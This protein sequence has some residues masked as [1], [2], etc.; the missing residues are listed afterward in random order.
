MKKGVKKIWALLAMLLI[1]WTSFL[2][3]LANAVF[4]TS[5]T[6]TF[7]MPDHNVN[8]KAISEANTYTIAFNANWWTGSMNSMSMTYD[9]TWTLTAN[10]F[11]KTW[12]TFQWWS[13]STDWDV[14]YADKATNVSNLTSTDWATV[15]L[16]AIWKANTYKVSFDK[17]EGVD[18]QNLVVWSMPVQDFI[19]D[20]SQQLTWNKFIRTWYTFQWWSTTANWAVVYADKANVSNLTTTSWGTVILYAKW[21]A[22][23]DTKYTVNH[24]LMGTGWEYSTPTDQ[25]EYE[26][27]T[28]E[29]VTALTGDYLWFTL[30]WSA[31]TWHVKWDWTTVFDYYYSRNKYDV[32]LHAWRG[33]AEVAWEGEYYYDDAISVSA[34]LKDWY[35][36][37]TLVWTWDKTTANFNM[38]AD[39]VDMTASATPF[40]YTITYDVWS[41][42][43]TWQKTTYNVEENFTLVD[44]TRTWY[45]FVWWSG[46]NLTSPTSWLVI[47]GV[48]GD[49]SYEAV[50]SPRSDITFVV[51]HY[52]KVLWED[53]YVEES[54]VTYNTWTADETLT[55]ADFQKTID[56][57]SYAWWSL[58]LS[59]SWLSSAISTTTVLPDGSRHIY[60]YYTRNVHSVTLTKDDHIASVNLSGT[61]GNTVTESFECWATVTI[62]ADPDTWYHFLRWDDLWP[63][64]LNPVNP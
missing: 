5:A 14:A 57:M 39:D 51:H 52:Q 58:V 45:D 17:N 60:L 21:N 41:W 29:V 10:S 43:I 23:T 12:Y 59:A 32:T 35:D 48:Y 33:I 47:S 2:T 44:P 37:S 34:T 28:Y 49:L 22:N 4:S 27:T 11:S 13:T 53:R 38:P 26:A 54:S 63:D 8:L 55:L 6:V 3:S 20:E 24:Y 36:P 30:S 62:D 64:F 42:T 56:C 19:F 31:K 46:T 40:T 15:T 18:N 1:M 50:W 16:Y 7:T 25:I 61:I 9:Q